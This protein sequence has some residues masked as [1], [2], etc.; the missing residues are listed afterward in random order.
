MLRAV[1]SCGHFYCQFWTFRHCNADWKIIWLFIKP[2]CYETNSNDTVF[3]LYAAKESRV[4]SA[5]SADSAFYLRFA[6][7]A[8]ESCLLNG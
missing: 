8:E 5:S 1:F 7:H 4:V 6:E 3:P 2:R